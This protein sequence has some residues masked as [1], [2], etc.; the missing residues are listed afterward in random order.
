[1]IECIMSLRREM[2]FSE[3]RFGIGI[4]SIIKQII[5]STSILFLNVS[6]VWGVAVY[7][8]LEIGLR[9]VSITAI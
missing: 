9:F 3:I 7:A 1:M 5:I 6:T 8:G 2:C 4:C